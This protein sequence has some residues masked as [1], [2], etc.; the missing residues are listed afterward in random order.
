MKVL[1]TGAN[2]F[3]GTRLVE[4][5]LACEAPSGLDVR[6]LSVLDRE[7]ARVPDDSRVRTV[8]GDLAH[9]RVLAE[10][11][12]SEPDLIFHLASI[13]GGLAEREFEL[14]LDVNLRASVE[15]LEAVRRQGR[16]PRFVFASS[17]AVYGVPMPSLIDENTPAAP[18]I[19]YGAHKR[20]VE[21]L[22]SDYSRRG[23][24]D[25]CSL[26]L[27][28]V[29]ARPS[30]P[31]GLV[32]AF[33]SDALRELAAGRPFEFPVAGNGAAWWMSREC[34]VRNL[35]RAG[36]LDAHDLQSQRVWL[37]PVLH[38]SM[39]QI[40]EAVADVYGEAVRRN[41]SFVPNAQIQAQF[42]SFPPLRCP[43][44]IE[45]GFQHDGTLRELVQR[46]LA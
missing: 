2:G 27:P 32:S 26:R 34:V 45:A 14:G 23:F 20:I 5:L 16:R 30:R 17:V 4:R 44:S 41:A 10:A 18:S 19:S 12:R 22:I 36:R 37:L 6:Q 28:G 35:L 13:P 43:S 33:M 1:V 24:L 9:A 31:S 8:V 15:L 46:A 25:G 21:L 3:I 11:L 42:A 39:L 29:V 40:V 38:A 7:F